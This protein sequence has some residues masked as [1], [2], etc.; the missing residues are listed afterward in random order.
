MYCLIA[1]MW[2]TVL[3]ERLHRPIYSPQ[4]MVL[5]DVKHIVHLGSWNDVRVTMDNVIMALEHM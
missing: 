5:L 4:S 1:L 2:S 3:Q